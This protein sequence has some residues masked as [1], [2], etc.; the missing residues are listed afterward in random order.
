V[1]K[2][3]SGS[4]VGPLVTAELLRRGANV[5]TLVVGSTYSGI[6]AKNTLRTLE[7]LQSMA[8]G[9]A[10][11][12]RPIMMIYQENAA[13][14][15]HANDGYLGSR[16]DIDNRVEEI[17]RQLG[18][19]FCGS[20]HELDHTDLVNWLDHSRNHADIPSQLIEVLPFKQT[21]GGKPEWQGTDITALDGAVISTASLLNSDGDEI[22]SLGQPYSCV[23][24]YDGKV[25]GAKDL[26]NFHFA[27]SASRIGQIMGGV[28]MAIRGY[29][30]VRESLATATPVGV[31][32][33][34]D[35][36]DRTT[37]DSGM[38]F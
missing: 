7:T 17:V 3:T 35:K 10:T 20:H 15:N 21:F 37:D 31:H 19:L 34:M 27:T 22:P 25:W 18:L 8:M 4:V 12:N 6:E 30:S 11:N 36:G 38:V 9:K 13:S 24:Y 32:Q 2:I 16:P 29:D 26:P 28:E 5:I 23:G 1:L 14:D 33:V